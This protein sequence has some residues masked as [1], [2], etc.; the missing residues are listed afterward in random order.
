MNKPVS[1]MVSG[2]LIALIYTGMSGKRGKHSRKRGGTSHPSS[3]WP[4]VTCAMVFHSTRGFILTGRVVLKRVQPK[5]F[6]ALQRR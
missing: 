6:V 3:Q 2:D 1:S 4:G 5:T